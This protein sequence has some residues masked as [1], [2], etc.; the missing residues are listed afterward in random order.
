MEDEVIVEDDDGNTRKRRPDE[1]EGA[2]PKKSRQ[3]TKSGPH[4]GSGS[5]SSG[6]IINPMDSQRH[7]NRKYCVKQYG[8]KFMLALHNENFVMQNKPAAAGTQ[9]NTTVY[10][11]LPYVSFGFDRKYWYM[12][13][14][15]YTN[16][17]NHTRMAEIKHCQADVKIISYRPYFQVGGTDLLVASNQNQ[18]QWRV[19]QGMNHILPY[20]EYWNPY[21]YDAIKQTIGSILDADSATNE[22]QIWHNI[23]H[24]L[25]GEPIYPNTP[26]NPP[27]IGA[28]DG[29]RSWHQHPTF[30]FTAPPA[31]EAQTIHRFLSGL[32]L[33]D[34]EAGRIP[35][36]AL[37]SVINWSYTP[38]NGLIQQAP[39]SW[40]GVPADLGHTAAN[41]TNNPVIANRIRPIA[42]IPLDN[43]QS[44]G[45]NT[46]ATAYSMGGVGPPAEEPLQWNPRKNYIASVENWAATRFPQMANLDSPP[47]LI[48]GV[49]PQIN[50][51]A[52]G[53]TPSAQGLLQGVTEIEVTTRCF[54]YEEE[55]MPLRVSV[56]NPGGGA[57]ETYTEL[58]DLLTKHVCDDTNLIRTG[59]SNSNWFGYGPGGHRL[60]KVDISAPALLNMDE[61]VNGVKELKLA[62]ETAKSKPIVT[63][64]KK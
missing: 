61:F 63:L 30:P 25:Y 58:R 56:A 5:G 46:D 36:A 40:Y 39:H 54:V 16:I 13:V 38:K 23:V 29:I 51:T 14:G 22:N 6:T 32:S 8:H 59:F 33:F 31:G 50:P 2:T 18:P 52:A 34:H 27:D 44:A 45:Q 57:T 7:L 4:P 21:T 1:D 9:A 62:Q 43:T 20:Q 49:T 37:E 3:A 35:G 47:D 12:D 60:A 53:T 11:Q 26:T 10:L 28:C 15:E 42:R 19:W 64:R 41:P 17:L 24:R 48:L 55:G